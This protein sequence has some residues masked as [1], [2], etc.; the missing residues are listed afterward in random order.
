M[1]SRR[2]DLVYM[3]PTL[4]VLDNEA[5]SAAERAAARDANDASHLKTL[6]S[7]LLTEGAKQVGHWSIS[8]INNSK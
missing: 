5:V 8:G 1:T 3:F 6:R 7:S 4:T 2:S